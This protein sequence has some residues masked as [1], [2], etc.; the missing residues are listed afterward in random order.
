MTSTHEG[1][2][3]LFVVGTPIGNL[4]DITLRAEAT[5]KRVAV[6]VAEDTRRTRALLSHLGITKKRLLAVDAHA[7]DARIAK[8]IDALQAGQDVALVTDAGMPSVSDPGAALVRAAR[9]QGVAVE[10]VPG[11]SAVTTAAAVSGLVEGPFLF[12]GFLPRKG[13]KRREAIT[14]IRQTHDAVILFEAPGRL[15]A[16]LADLAKAQPSRAA[17]VC[18][19]L[20]K[21]HE[22]SQLGTLAELAD[23]SIL[24]RGEFTLVLGPVLEAPTTETAEAV[25]PDMDA[26]LAAGLSVR[27][28]ARELAERTGHSRRDLFQL[29]LTRRGKDT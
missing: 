21:L 5:L 20:T 27:D 19:E 26:M 10:V 2:G 16:T 24:E 8:V 17:C 6:V 11:P 23:A 18:R 15:R 13:K 22:D 14:R 3:R 25:I 9:E 29:A 4:Q 7:T 28:V 1:P 12:A